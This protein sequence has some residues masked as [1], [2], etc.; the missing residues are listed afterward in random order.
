MDLYHAHAGTLLAGLFGAGVCAA[1]MG[2][3]DSHI[4]CLGSMFTQD[5]VAHYGLIDDRNDRVKVLVA[6][7]FVVL[8]LLAVFLFIRVV[9]ARTIFSTGV[10]CFSAFSCLF[11]VLLAALFWKRSTRFGA[12]LS[13]LSVLFL[14]AFL[15]CCADFGANDE[16]TITAGSVQTLGTQFQN[17]WHGVSNKNLAPTEGVMPVVVIWP[18]AAL[19][20]VIGSLVTRPPS[21]STLERFFPSRRVDVSIPI[22]DAKAAVAFPRT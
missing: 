10:W 9:D 1:I 19:L 7:L 18:I 22:L 4:L 11:P 17:A 16:Y 6:R 14:V 2:S 20:M 15:Y 3:L 8:L 12:Y 5:V 13:T 21:K